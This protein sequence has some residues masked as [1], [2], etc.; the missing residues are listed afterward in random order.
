V[1][2]RHFDEAKQIVA[3]LLAMHGRTY[4]D[5]KLGDTARKLSALVERDGFPRLVAALVCTPLAGDHDEV[6]RRAAV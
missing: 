1:V 2:S 6:K 4:C 5:E 3:A